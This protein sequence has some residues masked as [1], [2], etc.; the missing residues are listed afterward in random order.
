MDTLGPILG[1][2]VA[3]VFIG[4]TLW[5]HFSRS[6][7]I[8]EQWG[9]ENGYRIVNRE[10]RHVFKGPFFWTSSQG[11]TVYYVTVEDEQGNHRH[12]W[13]RCGSRFFGLLSDTAE[14]RWDD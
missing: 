13:V 14:V 1:F 12:G 9:Q 11:Q 6:A 4:L 5:W 2:L 3:A 8:L 7:S 10:Y